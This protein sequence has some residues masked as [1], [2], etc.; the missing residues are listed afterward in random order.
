[1][2]F[3]GSGVT[4]ALSAPAKGWWVLALVVSY[5][6]ALPLMARAVGRDDWVSL[7][8]FLLPVSIFQILPDWVLAGLIGTLRFPEIGGPR[9]DDTINLAMGGMWVA[10][11]F[12]VL[13][14]ARGRA[15]VAAALALGVFGGSELLAPVLQLW[16][17]VGDT[18][19]VAG[20]ALYVLPAEAALGAATA[21]AYTVVREAGPARRVAAALA[22]STFYLGA[23]VLS[24]FII[25]IAG[26]S[27]SAG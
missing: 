14:L 27:I 9:I 11:L 1:M 18:T 25:D 23:L 16:E 7:W 2:F 10:P 13:V 6:V 26:W 19:E 21:M 8:A 3:A 24:H 17:P 15:G 12:I 5:N 4:A 22:V 20:V